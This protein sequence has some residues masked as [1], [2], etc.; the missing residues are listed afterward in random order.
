MNKDRI[1]DRKKQVGGNHYNKYK[2]QPWDVIL[3]YKLDYFEG[4]TL[5]YLLRHK[6][7]RLEDLKKAAHYLEQA[8]YNLEATK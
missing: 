1:V 2:I 3:A 8:I 7:N 6:A 4:N 5:K